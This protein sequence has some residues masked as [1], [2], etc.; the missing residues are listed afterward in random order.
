MAPP[1]SHHHHQ[2]PSP[3]HPI[4]V[5]LSGRNHNDDKNTSSLQTKSRTNELMPWHSKT[6]DEAGEVYAMSYLGWGL[7]GGQESKWLR[8]WRYNGNDVGLARGDVAGT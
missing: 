4:A 8:S 7:A 1:Q 3:A 6:I 5:L 2:L